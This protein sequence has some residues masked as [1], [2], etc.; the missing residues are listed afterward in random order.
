MDKRAAKRAKLAGG[1][2]SAPP[3]A[4][5]S[6]KA[7][8]KSKHKTQDVQPLGTFDAAK[9]LADDASKDDEE[10]RLEA[11]LFGVPYVPASSSSKAHL[12]HED[13]DDDSA[14]EEHTGGRELENMLDT[15]VSVRA[16]PNYTELISF[17][18]LFRR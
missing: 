15:D 18:A 13:D 6:G 17:L 4:F 9:F 14:N 7:S 8:K 10:R 11:S 1:L 2:S 16:E 3:K 12:L 5:T